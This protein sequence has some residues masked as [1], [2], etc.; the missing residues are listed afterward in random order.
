MDQVTNY[1]PALDDSFYAYLMRRPVR[2]H[3]EVDAQ[4]HQEHI[5][6]RVE[7]RRYKSNW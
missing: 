6:E 2:C 7:D 1:L 3:D 5:L 4:E